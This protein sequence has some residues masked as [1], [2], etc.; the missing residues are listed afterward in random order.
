MPGATS[1][2]IRGHLAPFLYRGSGVRRSFRSTLGADFKALGIVPGDVI[3]LHASF[4][5]LGPVESGPDVVIDSLMD[6]VGDHGGILMFVSWAHSPYDAFVK[7]K[8]LTEGERACWPVFDPASAEVRPSYAGAIGAGLVRR[9][10]AVRSG[11][12]DRSL[13]ALGSGAAALVR[14]HPL[15]HGFGPGS[16]L[17]R[18]VERGGK[19]LLLGA[20][21]STV[22]VI[23]YAEYLCAVP[24]KQCINY[25]VP[26]LRNGKKEWHRVAQMNRD[27]FVRA[28]QGAEED[29]IETVV[30]AY[31]A[32]GRQH[33][34]RVGETSV[35]LFDARDLVD[36]AVSFFD[37]NYGSN[38]R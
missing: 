30:R 15:D 34:G 36:F 29:Y 26:L 13:A 19:S 8:G 24:D 2:C 21:L 28:V 38:R 6:V 32:T 18:F 12:P 5:S 37:R 10:A 9:V 3:M 7:D 14:E 23:H 4:K 11:N 17:A 1:R 16:P 35:Y 31:L 22:T 25:E 33:N 20:P 27:G